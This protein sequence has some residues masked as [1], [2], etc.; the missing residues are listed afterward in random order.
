[1]ALSPDKG[2]EGPEEEITNQWYWPALQDAAQ[3]AIS[4]VAMVVEIA[5]A[6]T[7]VVSNLG[8]P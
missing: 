8:G 2:R 3:L 6:M 7:A 4:G 1:M 5:K